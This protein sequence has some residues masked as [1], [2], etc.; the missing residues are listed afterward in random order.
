MLLKQIVILWTSAYL[1]LFYFVEQRNTLTVI[2]SERP[3]VHGDVLVQ[4]VPLG[5]IRLIDRGQADD[6]IIAYLQQVSAMGLITF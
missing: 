6:K 5:G 1:G 3:I 4:A 2:L